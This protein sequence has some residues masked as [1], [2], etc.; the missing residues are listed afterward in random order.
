MYD[1]KFKLYDL[2]IKLYDYRNNAILRGKV[3]L[4]GS[5]IYPLIN[6]YINKAMYL[7]GPD[8]SS[9]YQGNISFYEVENIITNFESFRNKSKKNV[10]SFDLASMLLISICQ[11]NVI[12]DKSDRN[13]LA[14]VAAFALLDPPFNNNRI[15]S[16]GSY[17]DDTEEVDISLYNNLQYC[18]N[19]TD[20]NKIDPSFGD[21]FS[22]LLYSY[23]INKKSDASNEQESI[24]I[25]KN[26]K[27][28]KK[29]N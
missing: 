14:I 24:F 9:K 4:F 29:S 11:S 10:N 5:D 28:K 1:L 12:E 7:I 17:F 26:V 8:F 3:G 20:L 19:E 22:D 23:Y 15:M 18:L 27:Q 2:K 21:M 25:K 6:G 13:M 16:T